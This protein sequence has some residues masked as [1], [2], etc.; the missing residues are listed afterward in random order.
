VSDGALQVVDLAFSY[1]DKADVLRTVS[2]TLH[3]GERVGIVGPNG[4]GKTSLFLL[5]C[6]VLSPSSG[7]VELCGEPVR[8]GTC[9]RGI[10]FLFQSPDDQLFSA[11]VF[12]DIAFGPLNMG[13]RIEQIRERTERLL[14]SLDCLH[15]IDKPP[16]HLSG[17]ERRMIALATILVMEPAVLLLDEPTSNL[18]LRNRRMIISTLNGLSR[19]MLVS[20]HDLEFLLETCS[21]AII[22][23]EGCTVADGPIVDIFSDDALMR[24]HHLEK[25]HSLLPHTHRTSAPGQPGTH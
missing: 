18:D 11:T 21:R 15:L 7:S 25:P 4:S 10:G 3:P 9:N 19:S 14:R 16:S 24:A 6:G 17:G 8:H 23:D 1:P 20:S 22:L 13:E 12:D 5:L 2:F